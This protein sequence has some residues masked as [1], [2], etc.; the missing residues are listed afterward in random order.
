M[1]KRQMVR[2]KDQVPVRNL[3]CAKCNRFHDF[4]YSHVKISGGRTFVV[5]YGL[6]CF[7]EYLVQVYLEK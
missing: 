2:V 5:Y 7:E 4:N 6:G 3:Y 1:D